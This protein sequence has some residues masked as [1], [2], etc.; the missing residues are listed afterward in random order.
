MMNNNNNNNF[1]RFT[2]NNEY[3]IAFQEFEKE[4]E[5]SSDRGMVLVCGSIIDRLLHDLLKSFLIKSDNVEKDLFKS[6]GV[7]ATFDAKIKMAYYLGLI[8][9]KE[10]QNI[11][12]LQRIRNKFAHQFLGISFE[13]NDIANIC[14]NFEIPKN[15]FVPPL[16]PFPDKETGELPKV[17]LNPIKR[18]TS[19]KDRFTYAFKY[20]YYTLINRIAFEEIQIRDEYEKVMT[21][22]DS[23]LMQIKAIENL[24]GYREDLTK[25]NNH[26]KDNKV[27]EMKDKLNR[28]KEMH[29]GNLSQDVQ[30]EIEKIE[31]EIERIE[32]EDV[33]IQKRYEK[34]L[35]E[36]DE[37]YKLFDATLKLKKYSYDVLKKSIEK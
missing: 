6:N 13:S 4:L 9:K 1:E 17:E 27:L 16:I 31:S 14:G 35:L 10:Q 20:I 23:M 37:H 22:E 33:E 32:K 8:S 24:M 19:A 7:L 29:N 5:N 28:Y 18:T 15:S 26:F 3:L 21:A 11:T 36:T 12:Y 2:K 25:I 30:D 34:F